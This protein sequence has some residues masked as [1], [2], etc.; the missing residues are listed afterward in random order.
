LPGVPLGLGCLGMEVTIAA[1]PQIG[2]GRR[3]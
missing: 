1:V 3:F 2:V